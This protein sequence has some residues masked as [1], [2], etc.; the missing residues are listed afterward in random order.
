MENIMKKLHYILLVVLS[1]TCFYKQSNAQVANKEYDAQL[2][3]ELK[4][5]DYGMKTYVMAILKTGSETNY[6]KA[7]QDSIFK[8]HM[9][10]IKRLA[11]EGKLV[12]AGPMG[13]NEKN[14]RG[15]FI[16]DVSTIAEARKLVDTDPVI[17][18][19]LMDVE[20]FIW[21]GSAALKETLK[22]HHKIE[23]MNF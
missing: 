18:S 5:D 7:K 19:K 21:Y 14:Y 17:Q 16:F 23:K 8:G 4:A 9:A 13:K 15:I 10:N 2:A 1:I 11:A 3:K 12:V 22:I 20:L 6:P